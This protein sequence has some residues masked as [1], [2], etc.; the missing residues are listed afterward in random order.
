MQK[1]VTPAKPL[2]RVLGMLIVI[3][4]ALAGLA[5]LIYPVAMSHWYDNQQLALAREYEERNRNTAPAVLQEHLDSAHAYNSRNSGGPILDPW[6]SRVSE[7]NIEYQ[8]YLSELSYQ[9]VMARLVVPSIDVDLPIYHGTSERS[10]RNGVGHLYGSQLPVG[11]EGTHSLLTG[12]T[13]LPEATLFD[14]LDQLEIGDAFYLSVAGDQLK[15]EVSNINVVLPNETDSL[16][17]VAGEDLVT[18]ITCTPYGINTHRLLVTGHRVEMDPEQKI[19][20]GTRVWTWW[21]Y[22]LVAAVALLILSILLFGR[23]VFLKQKATAETDLQ[24]ES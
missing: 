17:P 3:L 22:A 16:R 4:C 14:D 15:Y 11:G 1:Q 18:L 5:L 24:E 20:S 23:R 19:E 13:G 2:P 12:H 9:S 7:S 10:L 21:M 6:L 8:E